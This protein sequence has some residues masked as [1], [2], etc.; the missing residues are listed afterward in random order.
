ML[1]SIE[2]LDDL[3]VQEGIACFYWYFLSVD[4]S[5]I[6]YFD[7]R[8]LLYESSLGVLQSLLASLIYRS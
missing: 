7:P 4:L 5:V 6:L 8:S 1:Y 2:D 3:G